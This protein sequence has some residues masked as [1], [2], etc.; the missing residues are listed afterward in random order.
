MCGKGKSCP[1]VAVKGYRNAQN[2]VKDAGLREAFNI[3]C[4]A[5]KVRNLRLLAIFFNIQI[6]GLRDRSLMEIEENVNLGTEER[7]FSKIPFENRQIGQ[8]QI[9][10]VAAI[11]HYQRM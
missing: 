1:L 10:V 2:F 5:T 7:R 9:V 8:S 11:K 3:L 4:L 6:S